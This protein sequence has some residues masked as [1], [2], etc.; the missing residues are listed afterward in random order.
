M[1]HDEATLQ[2]EAVLCTLPPANG[3]PGQT[4]GTASKGSSNRCM[5]LRYMRGCRPVP[6]HS[7]ETV[8]LVTWGWASHSLLNRLTPRPPS[9]AALDVTRGGSWWWSPTKVKALQQEQ[10]QAIRQPK[11]VSSE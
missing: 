3:L 9:S 2:A 5:V 4:A 10:Q 11:G 7:Q 8:E 1:D 6:S